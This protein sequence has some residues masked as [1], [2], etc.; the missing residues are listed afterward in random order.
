M[1]MPPVFR[2]QPLITGSGGGVLQV[3][4][5]HKHGGVGGIC[6]KRCC[7][8]TGDTTRFEVV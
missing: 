7:L 5:Q 1:V 4:S 2:D 3:L 8:A 6:G